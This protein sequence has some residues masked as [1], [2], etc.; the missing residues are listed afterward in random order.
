MAKPEGVEIKKQ[1]QRRRNRR[2]NDVSTYVHNLDEVVR[3]LVTTLRLP[4]H[5]R[6]RA[7]L[8]QRRQPA[9]RGKKSIEHVACHVRRVHPS[10]PTKKLKKIETFEGF[11]DSL[12][13][14]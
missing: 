2:N 9:R 11:P 12:E 6:T 13:T 14:Y 8:V 4:G 3:T 7:Q 1:C 5:D 10:A